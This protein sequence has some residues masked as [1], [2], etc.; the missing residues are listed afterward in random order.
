M[1]I[2]HFLDKPDQNRQYLFSKT[3]PACSFFSA[4]ER[5]DPGWF[6]AP[7]SEI[8][9]VADVAIAEAMSTF[10]S[11]HI[12]PSV[13]PLRKRY[14]LAGGCRPYGSVAVCRGFQ[15]RGV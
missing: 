1:I 8:R 15:P 4:G 9:S 3:A 10:V 13:P 2:N 11:L 7:L 5:A 6:V 12:P 14:G